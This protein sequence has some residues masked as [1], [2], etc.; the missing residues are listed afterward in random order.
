MR[1]QLVSLGLASCFLVVFTS[2]LVAGQPIRPETKV[3]VGDKLFGKR[4][5][6]SIWSDCEVVEISGNGKV[7]LR[8]SGL[9]DAFNTEASKTALEQAVN[10]GDDDLVKVGDPVFRD[11]NGRSDHW[12]S[13]DQ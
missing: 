7:K 2:A 8:W 11:A 10:I 6:N 3:Q 4:V 12:K 5:A 13:R 1:R 9:P